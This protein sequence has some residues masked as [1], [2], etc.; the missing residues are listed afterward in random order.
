MEA[1]VMRSPDARLDPPLTEATFYIMLSMSPAPKHGYAILKDVR[2]LSAG[3]VALSTGT[4]YGAI[5]RLLDQ[6]WIERT[7]DPLPDQTA[8]K[9]QTYALTHDG[10]RVLDAEL[11]RLQAMVRA[12][13]LQP[14]GEGAR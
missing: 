8:R 10:R 9:R 7:E 11:R 14:L 1:A 6:G 2:F 4:L 3:Q 12:A 5:R 13:S